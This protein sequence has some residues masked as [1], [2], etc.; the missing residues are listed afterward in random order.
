[1]AIADDRQRIM[2]MPEDREPPR[3]Y[4]LAFKE[5]V[6]LV[7]ATNPA[8]SGE[9]RLL[10]CLFRV[11]VAEYHVGFVADRWIA[12]T[13]TRATMRT[14]RYTDGSPFILRLASG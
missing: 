4:P 5:A 9:V 12:S 3:G 11:S 8:L 2:P 14:A 10:G 6:R 13:S 1:M 7:N